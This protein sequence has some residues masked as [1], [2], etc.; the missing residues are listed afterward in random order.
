MLSL[1]GIFPWIKS[2]S[3]HEIYPEAK[4]AGGKGAPDPQCPFQ[5]WGRPQS[6]V[7]VLANLVPVIHN[8]G[9]LF[10]CGTG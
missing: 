3:G 6:T 2:H 5:E 8:Q 1:P 7:L 9:R 10:V 4:D